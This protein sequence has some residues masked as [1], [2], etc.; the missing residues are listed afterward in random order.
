MIR[1]NIK[2]VIANGIYTLLNHRD[3]YRNKYKN[4][5]IEM[6]NS[7]IQYFIENILLVLY[8]ICPEFV[9]SLWDY[10]TSKAI[11]LSQNWPI[12]S[13]INKK[14]MMYNNIITNIIDSCRKDAEHHIKKLEKQGKYVLNTKINLLITYYKEYNDFEKGIIRQIKLGYE[15]NL[16]WGDIIKQIMD[17]SKD[18]KNFGQLVLLARMND[19]HRD[20]S[21]AD[22][23]LGDTAEEE[24]HQAGTRVGGHDDEVGA[25]LLRLLDD[26]C[27]RVALG[28]HGLPVRRAVP[29]AESVKVGAGGGFDGGGDFRGGLQRPGSAKRLGSGCADPQ[30]INKK[31]FLISL[32]GILIHLQK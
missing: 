32:S 17:G 8:P 10:A 24:A 23:V 15:A 5:L 30:R 3:E 1:W 6:N 7:V 29:T 25:R 28:D 2:K 22:D 19:E 12:D 13:R 11:I 20:A 26:G 31:Q 27:R 16:E 14:I 18:K 21:T 4:G 9:E